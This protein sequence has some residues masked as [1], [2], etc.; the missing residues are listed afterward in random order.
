MLSDRQ[1]ALLTQ[2][3]H[4]PPEGIERRA[5]GYFFGHCACGY[6]SAR[7]RT[8]NQAADALIHH[9]RKVAE[10]LVADGVSVPLDGI[11]AVVASLH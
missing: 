1:C 3:Y 4:A 9:M 7:R 8:P 2:K 10:K 5:N 11:E 6:V